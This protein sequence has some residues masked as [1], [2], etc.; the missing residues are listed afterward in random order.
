MP[1]NPDHLDWTQDVMQQ[2]QSLSPQLKLFLDSNFD[3]KIAEKM[4]HYSGVKLVIIGQK[5]VEWRSVTLR[6][7]IHT[8]QDMWPIS[9]FKNLISNQFRHLIR[10]SPGIRIMFSRKVPN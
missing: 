9:D 1:L 4:R 7:F 3:A 6:N 8:T 2:I 10:P 5:E